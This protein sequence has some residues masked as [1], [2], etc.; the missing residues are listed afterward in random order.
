MSAVIVNVRAFSG[1]LS[2]KTGKAMQT[3]HQE[4]FHDVVDKT[5][6][7]RLHLASYVPE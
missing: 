7:Y 5:R 4:V 6:V 1:H 3:P 2:I